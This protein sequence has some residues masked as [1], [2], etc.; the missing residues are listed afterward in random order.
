MVCTQSLNV[1]KNELDLIRRN[2]NIMP[3]SLSMQRATYVET[4]DCPPM[5]I[6]T[7]FR[8][9]WPEI[10]S[11]P[12]QCR[13]FDWPLSRESPRTR[14]L[15]AC[16]SAKSIRVSMKFNRTMCPSQAQH[17]PGYECMRVDR[18]VVAD[19]VE[20][21]TDATIWCRPAVDS[22]VFGCQSVV[23]SVWLGGFLVSHTTQYLAMKYLN[24]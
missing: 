21:V 11:M 5:R 4:F 3:L 7:V 17:S 1:T 9:F 12:F 14:S 23:G 18:E 16:A 8:W 2:Q 24:L 20:Y 6:G 15:V 13:A 22:A 19:D 10:G